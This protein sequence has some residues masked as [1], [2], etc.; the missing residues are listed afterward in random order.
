MKSDL[1]FALI[2]TKKVPDLFS[3]T[4]CRIYFLFN[5]LEQNQSKRNLPE[6]KSGTFLSNVAA[7]FSTNLVQRRRNLAQGIGLDRVH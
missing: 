4:R 5:S 3:K 6:N 2:V 1:S 7:I